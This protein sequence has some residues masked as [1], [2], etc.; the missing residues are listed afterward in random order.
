M[1]PEF[2]NRN[3]IVCVAASGIGAAI[4]KRFCE[5]GVVKLGR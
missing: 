2:T 4:A 1:E 3:A 5:V